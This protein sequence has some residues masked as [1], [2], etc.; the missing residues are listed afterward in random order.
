MAER[1]AGQTDKGQAG[2]KTDERS[3][4]LDLSNTTNHSKPGREPHSEKT[5]ISTSGEK[6]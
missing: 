3:K 2:N 6:L 1:C 5:D 4:Q